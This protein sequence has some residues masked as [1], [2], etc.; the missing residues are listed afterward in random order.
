M[1]LLFGFHGKDD[2]AESD[3]DQQGSYQE[4]RRGR[5]T[6]S[7][8]YSS[9]HTHKILICVSDFILLSQES[10]KHLGVMT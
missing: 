2:Q 10:K 7:T 1:G 8:N 6:E 9:I 5:Q 3:N 4:S